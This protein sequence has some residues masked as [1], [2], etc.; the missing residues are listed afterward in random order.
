[1]T[2][3][4]FSDQIFEVSFGVPIEFCSE[5]VKDLRPQ[6]ELE[7]KS[8]TSKFRVE[9]LPFVKRLHK[10]E[11]D[12]IGMPSDEVTGMRKMM[13]AKLATIDARQFCSQLVPKLHSV[14]VKALAAAAEQQYMAY[15][16]A[17]RKR[18]REDKK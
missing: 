13:M 15:M 18:T 9:L 14:D 7:A 16:D 1:M 11:G 12:I 2:E 6:I 5:T 3:E 10:D 17:A 4:A 8:L